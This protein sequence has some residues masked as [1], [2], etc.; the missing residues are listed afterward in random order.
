MMQQQPPQNYGAA[1][2][3]HGGKQGAVIVV[4]QTAVIATPMP[5]EQLLAGHPFIKVGFDVQ[6]MCF[7]FHG[8]FL[9]FR[10]CPRRLLEPW[11]WRQEC[12]GLQTMSM[13]VCISYLT[14]AR[15]VT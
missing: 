11:K 1:A 3:V 8:R 12:L 9:G 5:L 15:H 13:D 4:P 14:F 7:V 10:V 6:K 2:P